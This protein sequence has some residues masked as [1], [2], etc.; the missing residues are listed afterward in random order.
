MP[1]DAFHIRRLAEELNRT[2]TGGKVNRVSQADKDEITLI[3]YTKTARL[4]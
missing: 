3:I 1:Q 2:L 4:N